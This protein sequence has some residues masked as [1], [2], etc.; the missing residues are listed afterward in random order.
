MPDFVRGFRSVPPLADHY[1]EARDTRCIDLRPNESAILTQ[2]KPKGRYNIGVAR[3]HSVSIV[4]DASEQG[5][6]DFLSI[7]EETAIRQGMETK[8]PDYFEALLSFTSPGNYGSLFFAEYKEMR[9]ATALVLYFGSRATYFYG[10]SRALNRQVMAPYLMHFEIMRKAKARGQEWYDLWG[11]APP[12]QPA[13][14]WQNFTAFKAKFGGEEVHLVPTL[15][16]VFDAAA[17]NRYVAI[18]NSC[19]T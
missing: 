1:L 2:M 6:A 18:E 14:P 11:I 3:R 16:L 13:H 10:G 5:L 19:E 4:E 9:L 15:D 8:P 7:Y 12:N 17:Y